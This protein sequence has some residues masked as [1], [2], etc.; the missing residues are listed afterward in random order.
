MK[1]FIHL[2][3]ILAAAFALCIYA[4]AEGAQPVTTSLQIPLAGTPQAFASAS[5][6]LTTI[7]QLDGASA[8]VNAATGELTVSIQLSAAALDVALAAGTLTAKIQLDG[9]AISSAIANGAL[10][11][12]S[13]YAIAESRTRKIEALNRTRE[14]ELCSRIRKVAH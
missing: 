12:A 14:V 3:G 6:G 9:A 11:G 2:A 7:I 8:S 10:G 1:R 13:G 5:G 4:P